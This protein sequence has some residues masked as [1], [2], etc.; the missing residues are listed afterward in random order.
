MS[1][2]EKWKE[3]KKLK[4]EKEALEEALKVI[5]SKITT[6][7]VTEIPPL[8]ES[9]EI[10]KMTIDEVGTCFIQT[11]VYASIKKEDQPLVYR[12]L[13]KNKH[14]ALIVPYIFPQTLKSFAKEQL[15]QGKPLHDK[16]KVTL[17]PTA[18][19]RSN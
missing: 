4:K 13:K 15:E 10:D 12:W 17:V 14:G 6:L 3:L 7:A 8:M 19:I 18:S 11:K 9:S 5:D 2:L 1:L 16:L